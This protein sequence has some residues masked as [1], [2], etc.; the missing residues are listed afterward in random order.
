MPLINPEPKGRGVYQWQTSDDR[1]QGEYICRI[2][3]SSRGSYDIYYGDV[4]LVLCTPYYTTKTCN[5][6]YY[7]LNLLAK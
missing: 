5:Y 1:G 2:H 3:C 4:I 6:V 7:S